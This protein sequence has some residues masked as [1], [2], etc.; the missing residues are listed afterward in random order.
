M[1]LWLLFIS[2]IQIGLLSF[3]GG[4]AS[5]PLIQEQVITLHHWI[6]MAEFND[7]ITISQMTPG[8][9]A[10]NAATFVGLKMADLPGALVATLGCVIPSCI[11]VTLLVHFYMKY[12]H[13][14][15]LQ[16]IL[17]TLRPAVVVMIATAGISILIT[18]FFGEEGKL[19]IEN[20]KI[21]MVV[22]FFVCVLL[23]KKKDMNPVLVMFLAGFM[24][25]IYYMIT[26]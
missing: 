26:C 18:A 6:D 9:I 15:L 25:V 14:S 10:I 17:N 2:F 1:I 19:V 16:K 20:L 21:H 24:N 23:L 3:G 13:L 4:Y 8:P 7:L 5:L 11:I 12:K 22:I